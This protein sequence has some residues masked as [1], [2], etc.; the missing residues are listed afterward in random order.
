MRQLLVTQITM[1]AVAHGEQLNERARAEATSAK[2]LNL[3]VAP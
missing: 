3:G 1:D 2:S